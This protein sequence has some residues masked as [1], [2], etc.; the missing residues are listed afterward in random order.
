MNS[1][2]SGNVDQSLPLLNVADIKDGFLK[3]IKSAVSTIMIIISIIVGVFVPLIVNWLTSDK[4]LNVST[5]STTELLIISVLVAATILLFALEIYK[6]HLKKWIQSNQYDRLMINFG[7]LANQHQKGLSEFIT[8]ADQHKKGLSEFVSLTNRHKNDLTIYKQTADDIIIQIKEKCQAANH[9]FVHKSHI[10]EN[11]DD[12]YDHLMRTMNMTKG[13]AI[14]LTH[15]ID[16]IDKD[17]KKFQEYI[18]F[19]LKF[20]QAHANVSIY[21]IVTIHNKDKFKRC[22]ELFNSIT[23]MR[24]RNYKLA[25][26]HTDNFTNGNLPKVIGVQ[27]FGT[28]N[29]IL[30]QPDAAQVVDLHGF[31]KPMYIT[32]SEFATYFANYHVKLWEEISKYDRWCLEHGI[33]NSE[34]DR[35]KGHRGHILY[36]G[37]EPLNTIHANNVW[38]FIESKI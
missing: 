27:I 17:N 32:S 35:H 28:E 3:S 18:D 33:G 7:A 31:S 22:K 15:Y 38:D 8:L 1:N 5:L 6:C 13:G 20:C 36:N 21:K 11:I 14:R 34:T 24:L 2:Q 10:L 16:K 23:R 30:M 37:G 12:Y 4:R 26:L 19:E 25:Y 9:N 29:I